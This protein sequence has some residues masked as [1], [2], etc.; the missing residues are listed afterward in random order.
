MTSRRRPVNCTTTKTRKVEMKDSIIETWHINNRVNLMLIEAIRDEGFECTLSTR[1]GNT[2]ARQFAHLHDVRLLKL[3]K[4]D[5]ELLQGLSKIKKEES[6]HRAKLTTH[7]NAS[8]EAV[9]RMLER[10]A[11]DSG[12]IKGFKRGVITLLGYFICHK[13]HHR[14]NILLTLKQGGYKIPRATQYGIWAWNQI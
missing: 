14:G 12:K 7:L 10:G 1:G 4:F 11:A 2:V 5:K 9:A 13:A 8:A 6:V 3:E